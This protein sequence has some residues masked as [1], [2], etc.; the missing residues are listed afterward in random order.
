MALLQRRKIERLIVVDEDFRATGLVTVKDMDKAL[1][2]PLACKDEQGRLRVG[3]ASTVGDA[4][5]ERSMALIEAG[6]DVV[7]IDTAHGHSIHVSRAVERL[8]RETNRVQIVAGNVATYEG[9]QGPD[10]R[11]R[12]R[13]ESGHRPGLHLHHP[14]RRG[15]GRAPADRHRRGGSRRS[16]IGRDRDR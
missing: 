14:H 4:G 5:Y 13:G 1:A 11:G 2:Y 12:G 10:R 3:A 6:V 8:K 9:R 7:V 16:G 15:R